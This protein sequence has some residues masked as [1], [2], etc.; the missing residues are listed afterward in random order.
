MAWHRRDG[1]L[2]MVSSPLLREY[3]RFDYA[4]RTPK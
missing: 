2:S 1:E 4:D 3:A